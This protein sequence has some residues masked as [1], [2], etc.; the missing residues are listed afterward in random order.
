MIPKAALVL[1]LLVAT[2]GQEAA[3]GRE[4][5][6]LIDETSPYL[7]QHAY[8][9]VH[10]YPW[11]PEA[12]AAAREQDKPIF[13]SVGY[14]TCY[15]C[16]VMERESF[17]D[18]KVAALMNEHFICIKVDREERPDVD[19]IYMT[20]VQALAGRG[21]WPMS[22]FLEPRELKPFTGGTY[23]PPEARYGKPSF[24]Q[25]LGSVRDQWRDDRAAVL[26]KAGKIGDQVTRALSLS[27]QP[28]PLGAEQVNGA[29]DSLMGAY[30]AAHGGFRRGNPKFPQP[31]Q[32]EFLV[33]VA[34]GDPAAQDA[35]LHT[36]DRMAMG[37]INDQVGGGFHRYST[38][39]RWLVPHF[40]KMLYDN[41]QLAS[42]YARVHE[43]TGDAF[44][45]EVVE[46]TL[47]YVLREMTSADGAFYSAQD[48]E[49]NER[50]G[51]SYVWT[52]AQVRR[53]LDDAGV[54]EQ[55]DFAEV[56]Y[57]LTAGGNFIDPHHRAEGSKNVLYLP[58]R[59][60]VIAGQI[61]LNLDD[62]NERMSL[63]N[64]ALLAA[65]DG[66]EQPIT[67]DK[68]LTEWN[69]L[70]ISAMV[71][72]S[73]ALG[74]SRY[75]ESARR[76][77]T[78]VLENMRTPDGGLY[79]AWRAGQARIDGFSSD[80]AHFVRGLLALHRGTGERVWLDEAAELARVSGRK[81][82]DER[83]GVY[84]NTL[85]GQA[86]LFVRVA[87]TRDGVIPC[88]NS[89]M[90]MNL[91]DLCELTG[92]ASWLDE[93]SKTLGGLSSRI[94]RSPRSMPLA[95]VA[96]HRFLGRYPDRLPGESPG[97]APPAAAPEPVKI[98]LSHR[99]IAVSPDAPGALRVSFRID[100]GYHLNAHEP[101]VAGLVGLS[102]RV[103]GQGLELEVEYPPGEPFRNRLFADDLLVHTGVVTLPLTVRQTG[104][105]QG[106]AAL[107]VTYQVCTD[108]VCLQP[109]ERG[110]P[111]AITRGRQ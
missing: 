108:Q 32:L 42:V 109:V 102:V 44:Y 78:F 49:A 80:Y 8:N 39:Q 23:F 74:E 79:R 33:A 71:D 17:E 53:A 64:A 38:D 58:A 40:E 1:G 12:F 100:E 20:G 98:S 96:L 7:L 41:A 73:R 111:V 63:V 54:G 18:P 70:M 99:T 92:E 14:S 47:D 6:R 62:F 66:R 26:A 60:E 19:D 107:V 86:D 77:A 36:L 37:G 76:A 83:S 89:V 27:F 34:W 25:L 21:G 68:V 50:E 90:L 69:G 101:G 94:R 87:T 52:P 93:A 3:P 13:L 9:P 103:V 45:G 5:N 16:H 51:D 110:L 59:P 106:R 15:W 24:T 55:F 84:Y 48:A 2:G 85:A 22:V 95:T 10:W 29:A 56:A 82:R 67:D 4:A 91:L 75:L 57:G 104:S 28:Q 46:E 81:F 11:G 72:G 105:W 97:P 61:G 31:V 65:R 88:A 35:L 43:L 30:D